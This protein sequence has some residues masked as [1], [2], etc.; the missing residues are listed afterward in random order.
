M[1]DTQ[2]D[3][4]P[5][6]PPSELSGAQKE[7]H[8]YLDQAL[9]KAFGPKPNDLFIIQKSSGAFIG[10]VASFV[11]YPSL[12]KPYMDVLGAVSTLAQ[13][14]PEV[15]ETV[16]LAVGGVYQARYELYSHENVAA[17]K[18]K[19]TSN[20]ISDLK[21]GKE[22]EGLDEKSSIAWEIAHT[23]CVQKGPLDQK[24]WDQGKSILGQDA[25]MAVV[26]YVGLYAYTCILLNA[27]NASVPEG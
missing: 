7:A 15:R 19:L 12:A 24:L 20:Q 11:Q 27:V 10:P 18:T 13:L 26:H 2:E 17:K 14:S 4:I 1:S 23:L 25:V 8:D 9:K 5:A 3:R 21:A 22:P 6:V 16:I